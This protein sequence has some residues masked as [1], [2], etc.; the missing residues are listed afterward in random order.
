MRLERVSGALLRASPQ[1]HLAGGRERWRAAHDRLP[2]EI[3][4]RID[5]AGGVSREVLQSDSR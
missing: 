1:R 2:R 4:A 3:A 5:R